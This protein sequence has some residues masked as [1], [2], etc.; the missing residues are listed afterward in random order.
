[1][2]HVYFFKELN[3][4]VIRDAFDDLNLHIFCERFVK[5][6][7]NLFLN[8]ILIK[9]KNNE[10]IYFPVVSYNKKQTPKHRFLLV[11][12]SYLSITLQKKT[13]T[14]TKKKSLE[15]VCC[16]FSS[17]WML[18]KFSFLNFKEKTLGKYILFYPSTPFMIN[19]NRHK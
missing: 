18:S 2:C 5:S 17:S 11:I 6:P 10:K 15:E 13:K 3:K 8:L 4:R 14:K 9:K 7:C 16:Q 12:R 19:Y 1:M